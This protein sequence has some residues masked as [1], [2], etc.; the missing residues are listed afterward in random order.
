MYMSEWVFNL[1]EVACNY[2]NADH[3]MYALWIRKKEFYGFSLW[4]DVI[5]TVHCA[6]RHPH[7][8]VILPSALPQSTR[9]AWTRNQ[10]TS[11]ATLIIC[12]E[13]DGQ[14]LQ[15][16]FL[17]RDLS[18][19]RRVYLYLGKN[20]LVLDNLEVYRHQR[21]AFLCI[22]LL[23]DQEKIKDYCPFDRLSAKLTIQGFRGNQNI[24]Y[25]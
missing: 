6:S 20:L 12:S 18:Y 7:I 9:A 5:W 16:R 15:F 23:S 1:S 11:F 24:P 2:C 17:F 25:F 3:K 22:H 21:E 14:R 4:F 13:Q 10:P 8:V 19:S